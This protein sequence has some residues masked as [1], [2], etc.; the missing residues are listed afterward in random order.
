MRVYLF[1]QF[2]ATC[3]ILEKLD[4]CEKKNVLQNIG[5]SQLDDNC[6]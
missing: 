5:F 1:L 4:T 6:N 2:Y 3:K